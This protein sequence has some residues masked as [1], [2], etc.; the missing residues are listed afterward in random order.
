MSDHPQHDL[1]RRD[2]LKAGAASTVAALATLRAHA[3]ERQ[4]AA[5]DLPVELRVR[6]IETVRIGYVGVGRQGSAH[7]RNLLHIA[8]SRSA[9]SATSCRR[10]SSASSSWW[11]TPASRS[12]RATRAAPRISSGCAQRTDLDL[13]YTAT[14]WEWHVPG[15]R[16]RDEER[17]ARRHRSARGR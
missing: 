6:P 15:V 16:G 13:V 5:A 14:P 7:V 4:T 2:F 9:R 8:A 3:E 11:P 12:P 10:K 17:Q 1:G